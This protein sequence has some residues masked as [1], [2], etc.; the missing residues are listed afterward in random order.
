MSDSRA[1]MAVCAYNTEINNHGSECVKHQDKE[2]AV[3]SL[4]FIPL[5]WG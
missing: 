1:D 2:E 4:V 5:G 3:H